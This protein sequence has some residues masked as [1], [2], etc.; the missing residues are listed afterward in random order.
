MGEMGSPHMG[1]RGV[2]DLTQKKNDATEALP[3]MGR[4]GSK[5]KPMIPEA[6]DIAEKRWGGFQ[7]G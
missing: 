6:T 2:G 3:R 7:V 5:V 4:V 1:K